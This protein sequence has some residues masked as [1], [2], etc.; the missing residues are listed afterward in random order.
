MID[1]AKARVLACDR[2]QT[3]ANP[4]HGSAF[5]SKFCVH[6]CERKVVVSASMHVKRQKTSTANE[7]VASWDVPS[8]V[9]APCESASSWDQPPASIGASEDEH[10]EH[11]DVRNA[12]FVLN[13]RCDS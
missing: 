6:E 3:Q 11:W 10:I 1:V 8:D 7:S 13:L 12:C 9:C 2:E 5:S 4:E